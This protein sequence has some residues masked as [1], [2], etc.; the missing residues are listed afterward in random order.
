MGRNNVKDWTNSY[1]RL[2]PFIVPRS[3]S[4]LAEDDEY[5][6]FNVTVFRRAKDE[7]GHK[8]REKKFTVREFVYDETAIQ[9]ANRDMEELEA[10]EKELWVRPVAQHGESML[11]VVRSRSCSG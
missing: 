6:L 10:Q 5:G 1:E 9:K 4:K 7:F 11:T 3:S 2:C 8:C